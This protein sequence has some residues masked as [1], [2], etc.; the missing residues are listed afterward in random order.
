VAWWRN[1]YGVGLRLRGSRV[2]IAALRFQVSILGKLFTHTCLSP[3][4]IIWY[5]LSGG[6]A[7]R[8]GGNRRSGVALALRHTSVVIHLAGSR[9]TLLMGV[10][11]TLSLSTCAVLLLCRVILFRVL[12]I[13]VI[14]KARR[15]FGCR[16]FSSL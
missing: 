13:V 7:L 14:V 10:W 16:L 9:P 2:R 5:R 1:G 11:H 4:S 12:A 8:L 3:S 15:V 6:D